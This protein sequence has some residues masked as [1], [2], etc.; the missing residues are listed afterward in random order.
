MAMRGSRWYFFVALFL[1]IGTGFLYY[2][3]I[4]KKRQRNINAE[5]TGKAVNRNHVE[6]R[7]DLLERELARIIST[8]VPRSVSAME[9]ESEGI[10]GSA[11]VERND[12]ES[13]KK[14]PRRRLVSADEVKYHLDYEME[15]QGEDKTYYSRMRTGLERMLAEQEFERVRIGDVRCGS[16]LCRVLLSFESS[17]AKQKMTPKL[18]FYE[19]FYPRTI[20]FGGGNE[21]RDAIVYVAREGYNLPEMKN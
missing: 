20:T 2:K 4:K 15:K 11:S 12:V 10:G 14:R 7:I 5:D 17:E 6:A 1:I 21:S 8:K 3:N 16:T 9:S 19:P 18:K 13:K